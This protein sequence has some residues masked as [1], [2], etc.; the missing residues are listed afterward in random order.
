MDR[1][2][3]LVRNHDPE[4][5]LYGPVTPTVKKGI[6]YHLSMLIKVVDV[7]LNWSRTHIVLTLTLYLFDPITIY[8]Y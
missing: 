5:H 1:V 4:S 3:K 2:A 7:P 6:K 8:M